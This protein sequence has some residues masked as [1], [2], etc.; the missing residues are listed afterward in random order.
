MRTTELLWPTRQAASGS[1]RFA[2]LC[3]VLQLALMAWSGLGAMGAS[4]SVSQPL[5]PPGKPLQT[6]GT[7][8]DGAQ[9]AAET[10]LARS[11]LGTVGVRDSAARG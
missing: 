11:E 9:Y 5:H 6:P 1:L 3:V 4:F 2:A 7:V 10:A 8:G